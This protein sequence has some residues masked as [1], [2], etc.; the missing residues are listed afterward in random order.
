MEHFDQFISFAKHYGLSTAIAVWLFWKHYLEPKEKKKK[1]TYVSWQTITERQDSHSTKIGVLQT[2]LDRHLEKEAEED[3]RME[4]MAGEIK[5]IEDK[6]IT[7]SG[8]VFS[9]LK[10]LHEKVDSLTRILLEAKLNSQ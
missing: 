7:E 6:R 4:R 8:H 3:I 2:Q 5:S 9:Q 10:S 1:G